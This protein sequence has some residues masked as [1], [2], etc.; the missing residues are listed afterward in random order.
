VTVT[1]RSGER[2]T[3]TSGLEAGE[4]VA[5]SGISELK[6]VLGGE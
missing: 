4:R 3:L 6:V 1:G 2:V 5:M